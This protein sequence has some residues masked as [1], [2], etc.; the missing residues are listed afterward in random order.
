MLQ[1][2]EGLCWGDVDA[3]KSRPRSRVVRV[4]LV[5]DMLSQA[6]HSRPALTGWL[7]ALVLLGSLAC[8]VFK[9]G[10]LCLI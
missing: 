10:Y 1:G 6:T 2:R 5:N 9:A 3:Y 4:A 8:M 7:A